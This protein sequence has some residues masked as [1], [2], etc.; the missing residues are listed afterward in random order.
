M[1]LGEWNCILWNKYVSFL[2][3]QRRFLLSC[4]VQI[5]YDCS[6]FH[7]KI[8]ER[9]ESILVPPTEWQWQWHFTVQP[10]YHDFTI[11]RTKNGKVSL[12][13]TCILKAFRHNVLLQIWPMLKDFNAFSLFF[14]EENLNPLTQFYNDNWTCELTKTARKFP[15]YSAKLSIV[16]N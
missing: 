13:F 2:S 16:A 8:L 14:I 9:R 1:I 10:V 11:T 3:K 5:F 4:T 12:L 7:E 6:A 15:Q